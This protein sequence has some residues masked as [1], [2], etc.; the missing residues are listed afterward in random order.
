[1]CAGNMCEHSMSH[2]VLDALVMQH[3]KGAPARVF[4][5]VRI[6]LAWSYCD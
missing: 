6:A 1:M 4:L 2:L 5:S 3:H